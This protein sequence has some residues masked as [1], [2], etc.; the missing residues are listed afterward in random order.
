MNRVT[1]EITDCLVFIYA[2]SG[3]FMLCFSILAVARRDLHHVQ[4]PLISAVTFRI[5][6]CPWAASAVQ[7]GVSRRLALVSR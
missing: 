1:V 5:L 4:A 7:D 3:S 6:Q 2:L